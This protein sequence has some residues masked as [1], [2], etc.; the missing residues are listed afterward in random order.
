ML[1]ITIVVENE[2]I[3]LNDITIYNNI[4]YLSCSCLANNSLRIT[5]Q[6]YS[7]KILYSYDL[8]NWNDLLN[9]ELLLDDFEINNKVIYSNPY[10][11]ENPEDSNDAIL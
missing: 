3:Y 2:I 5:D 7:I 6:Q 1:K 10:H 4:Y 11:Y 9:Q 8:E